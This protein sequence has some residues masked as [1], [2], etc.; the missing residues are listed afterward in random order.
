MM[1]TKIMRR[2]GYVVYAEEKYTQSTGVVNLK[3]DRLANLGVVETIKPARMY[4]K[5]VGCEGV[6]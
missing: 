3:G 6:G 4:I 5:E 1:E 2:V